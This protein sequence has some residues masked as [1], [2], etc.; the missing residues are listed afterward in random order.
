MTNHNT[1]CIAVRSTAAHGIDRDDKFG[2]SM[3]SALSK[4]DRTRSKQHILAHCPRE[5]FGWVLGS[6]SADTQ[7]VYVLQEGTGERVSATEGSKASVDAL[8]NVLRS[9]GYTCIKRSDPE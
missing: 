3:S 2:R 8:V 1:I 9:R 7:Q 6:D 4:F 5:I